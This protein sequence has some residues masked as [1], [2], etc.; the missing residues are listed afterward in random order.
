MRDHKAH[1]SGT[2]LAVATVASAL[3]LA[4]P[5]AAKTL[6]FQGSIGPSGA[7]SFSL[8]GSKTKGKVVDLKWYR[9]PVK[10]GGS[11]DTSAGALNY[12]VPVE[13]GK[14]S[15]DAVLGNPNRP[16]AEAIITGK[17]N[18]DKAHG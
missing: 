11:H 1:R 10:C 17:L 12:S 6:D 14:F 15:A 3:A 5:A 13:K 7:I 2:T 16:K 9:L 8:K 4:T 18:G